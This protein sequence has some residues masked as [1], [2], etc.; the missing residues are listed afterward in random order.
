[1]YAKT[2]ATISLDGT[3]LS[4]HAEIHSD[5]EFPIFAAG[6]ELNLDSAKVSLG[7][8]G[9]VVLDFTVSEKVPVPVQADE[10]PS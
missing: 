8:S 10:D 5:N 3:L 1:M 6:K 4:F 2:E 7:P 9:N